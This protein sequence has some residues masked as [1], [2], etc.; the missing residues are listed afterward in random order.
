MVRLKKKKISGIECGQGGRKV[1]KERISRAMESFAGLQE[2]SLGLEESWW[3]LFEGWDAVGGDGS[4]PWAPSPG[5]AQPGKESQWLLS[6]FSTWLRATW[7]LKK[8]AEA[9]LM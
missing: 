4:P 3:F 5:G 6:T 1:E 7:R 2:T 8:G 9:L